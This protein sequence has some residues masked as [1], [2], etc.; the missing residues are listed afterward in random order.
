MGRYR[1]ALLKGISA[2]AV[3]LSEE[4]QELSQSYQLLTAK[5]ILYVCNVDEASAATG[6]KYV[7]AVREAV[8]NE[9]AQVIVLAVATEADI[10]ELETYEERQL[11]LQDMGLDEPGASVL[12]R[13][14]ISY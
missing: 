8:K 4:E 5:P 12:I 11:F 3:E 14:A 10:A 13:A 2:R 9:N 1:E 7:E 6:N